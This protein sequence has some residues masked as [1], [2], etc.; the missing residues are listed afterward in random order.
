MC[1]LLRGG[2]FDCLLPN[3]ETTDKERNDLLEEY[4]KIQ[5]DKGKVI[6]KDSKGVVTIAQKKNPI[7]LFND[8]YSYNISFCETILENK[9]VKKYIKD[10][11][12]I[13]EPKSNKHIPFVYK[14]M[15]VCSSIAG[16][17]KLSTSLEYD[18]PIAF[19][20]LYKDFDIRKGVSKKTGEE[21]SMTKIYATDGLC[22]VSMVYAWESRM[23]P[24]NKGDLIVAIGKIKK[25]PLY[26][27][28]ILVD[29]VEKL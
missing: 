22:N 2:A 26:G 27:Y 19:V 23:I 5:Q 8:N 21:Y 14:K 4:I 7:E 3:K 1:A 24:W 17:E 11:Y 6:K 25:H 18:K 15:N 13:L 28:Q 20:L 9:D 12:P 16:A 10:N 29:N